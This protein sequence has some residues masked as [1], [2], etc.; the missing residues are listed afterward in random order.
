VRTDSEPIVMNVRLED[1]PCART[2]FSSATANALI[3]DSSRGARTINAR[4]AD[5]LSARMGT[6]WTRAAATPAVQPSLGVSNAAPQISARSA[7][8]TS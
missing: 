2:S 1:A 5:A 8:L 7:P 3:A 6:T 4:R